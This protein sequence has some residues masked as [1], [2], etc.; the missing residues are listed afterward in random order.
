MPEVNLLPFDE[1][2]GY[3]QRQRVKINDKA[4]DLFYRWNYSGGYAVLKIV[5]VEDSAVVFNGKLCDKNPYEVKDRGTYEPL[6]VI[7]PWNVDETK[8]EVWVFW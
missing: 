2:L 5:R 7:F 1:K 6:F 3:P 8:A 4:Y